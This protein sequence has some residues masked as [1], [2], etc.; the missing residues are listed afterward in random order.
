MNPY[1]FE[2]KKIFKKYGVPVLNGIVITK[3]TDL[4]STLSMVTFP[5]ALK[6]QVLTGGRGLA[7]GIKF[8]ETKEEA[9]AKIQELFALKIK[10][11]PVE[12]ILIEKKTNIKKEVYLSITIDKEKNCPVLIACPE[13]GV[14]I[15][16][17]A[18]KSPEKI[19]KMEIDIFRGLTGYELRQI[20]KKLDMGRNLFDICKKMYT[21]FME[22]DANLVEINPLVI[23]DE[24]LLAVDAKMIIDD[25]ASYR[26]KIFLEIERKEDQIQKMIKKYGLS[27]YVEL[28]GDIG[29]ISDGAGTGMLTLDLINDYGGKAANFSELGG[30]TNAET[31]K[32]AMKVVSLNSNVKVLLISMIGGLNRMDE[33][34]E[35]IVAFFEE[36]DPIPVVIRMCGTLEDVGK[37]MLQENEFETC[38]N[39]YEA[40]QKAVELSK[41]C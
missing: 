31:M 20:A 41:R 37:K 27:T 21:L 22:C 24:A 26:Q 2:A 29:L 11:H 17:I 6:S 23:T 25:K 16:H 5:I 14:D 4:D 19:L 28:D 10:K 34:A 35:G 18:E 32:N 36:H 30:I 38:D 9:V 1:E 13:G 39:L 8:A 33:M 40:V 12:M 15:E 3:D 7:G